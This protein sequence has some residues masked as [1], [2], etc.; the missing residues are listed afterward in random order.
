MQ[1][2]ISEYLQITDKPNRMIQCRICSHIICSADKNY[3]LHVVMKETSIKES[4]IQNY[5]STQ[6][7]DKY[8]VFR[9]YF[10]PNCATLLETET[11]IQGEQ[12]IWDINIKVE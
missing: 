3:K 7:V 11:N 10:C 6:Y 2:I 8:M 1:L 9:R 4:N 5:D 12:P